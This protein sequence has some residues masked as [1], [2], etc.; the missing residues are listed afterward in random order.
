MK[1]PLQACLLLIMAIMVVVPCTAGAAAPSKAAGKVPTSIKADI[2]EYNADGQTVVFKGQ[3]YVKRTDFELWANTMTV[4]L[5]KTAK[6]Q[7]S[8]VTEGMSAGEIDRIVASGN[9]RMKSGNKHGECQK[10]TYF[11]KTGK[12]VMEGS[13]RLRESENTIRGH[14]IV[15][16][17]HENRSEVQGAAEAQFLAPDRTENFLHNKGNNSTK[18]ETSR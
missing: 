15:H 5:D 7:D 8:S 4:Y 3:V 12:F 13:P 11:A 16:Y 2:M 6:K 10:A 14:T 18:E 9:V 17:M 1:H